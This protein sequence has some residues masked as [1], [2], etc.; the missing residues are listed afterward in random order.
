MAIEHSKQVRA[1]VHVHR[2]RINIEIWNCIKVFDDESNRLYRRTCIFHNESTPHRISHKSIY[3]R[4]ELGLLGC[5]ACNAVQTYRGRSKPAE[6]RG[7]NKIIVADEQRSH[8]SFGYQPGV[9]LHEIYL[10]LFCYQS[11]RTVIIMGVYY[12]ARRSRMLACSRVSSW[13]LMASKCLVPDAGYLLPQDCFSRQT[14]SCFVLYS[15][16]RRT[17][18]GGP[19]T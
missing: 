3:P 14:F 13:R 2:K 12:L 4:N 16:P 10:A 19:D 18:D 7:W 8:R 1:D 6:T 5:L 9:I 15:P 17:K 11:S